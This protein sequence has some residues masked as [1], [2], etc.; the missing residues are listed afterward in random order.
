MRLDPIWYVGSLALRP[1]LYMPSLPDRAQRTAFK[2][3][4]G[5][6]FRPDRSLYASKY[7][8]HHSCCFTARW[9]PCHRLTGLP[10]I[11]PERVPKVF[12]IR[13]MLRAEFAQWD[14]AVFSMK[15]H[16]ADKRKR[17]CAFAF[18]Q[19]KRRYFE[20][21]SELASSPFPSFWGALMLTLFLP[22]IGKGSIQWCRRLC[23]WFRTS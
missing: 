7:A 18:A 3:S 16:G 9:W 13:F 23:Y 6:A 5:E 1:L 17:D 20:S 10:S 8:S 21:M 4:N 15:K 11:N 12:Q 22:Q 14:K 2:L 19:L